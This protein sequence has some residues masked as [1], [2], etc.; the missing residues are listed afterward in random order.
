MKYFLIVVVFTW[1]VAFG[2]V[3]FFPKEASAMPAFAR[4]YDSPCSSCHVAFPKLNEFGIEFR[5]RGYRME[6]DGAGEPVWKLP[7][8]PIGGIAQAVYEFKHD[9]GATPKQS[10]KAEV[11]EVEFL[12]GGVLAPNISF[13]GDFEA[14][15]SANESLTPHH[16]WIIFD[17]IVPDSQ[18]NLKAG[19]FHVDFPFLSDHRA[20]TLA[21][22]LVR[23]RPDGKEGIFFVKKGAEINGVFREMG[24]RYALG[25]GNTG[26]QN[27][28]N[29][30]GAL[31]AWVTQTLELMGFNQ[32]AG[33]ILSL[34]RNG[35]KSTG[36]DDSTEAFGGVL[37]LHYGLT[38]VVLGVFQYKGNKNAGV[39]PTRVVTSG[40]VEVLHSLA[41]NMVAVARFDFQQANGS[42][43][44]KHQ[45]VGDLQYFFHPNVKGQ[46]ELAYE[47]AKSA[48]GVKTDVKTVTAAI[49]FGF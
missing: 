28:T 39:D 6:K 3:T 30:L 2:L 4:K 9:D 7:G 43:A 24:T 36:T 14:D 22:Y 17:D 12:Y 10:S 46:V 25:V 21:S 49:T 44:R 8:I 37:D 29:N 27:A 41:E 16:A 45:L 19:K 40:L 20:P 15:L 34:D 18:L 32:T 26:V 23:F 35:N 48:G 5:Q 31:H 42:S 33:V 13:F 11:T 47:D 38:G 1:T